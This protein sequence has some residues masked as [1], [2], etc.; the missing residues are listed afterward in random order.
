MFFSVLD[1][2]FRVGNFVLRYFLPVRVPDWFPCSWNY[3]ILINASAIRRFINSWLYLSLFLKKNI[4]VLVCFVLGYF[5]RG[6]FP[7]WSPSSWNSLIKISVI[8]R[9]TTYHLLDK[10]SVFNTCIVYA[11]VKLICLSSLLMIWCLLSLIL[12]MGHIPVTSWQTC[13]CPISACL[14]LRQLLDNWMRK[15]IDLL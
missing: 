6:R 8:M 4:V 5:L 10:L 15:L 13:S 7:E 12:S 1:G 2:S 9:S 3:L 11:I 14:L